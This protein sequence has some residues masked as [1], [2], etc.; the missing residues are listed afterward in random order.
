MNR[1]W[2]TGFAIVLLLAPCTLAAQTVKGMVREQSDGRPVAGAL[3]TLLGMGGAARARSLTR[4]DG[5]YALTAPTAG[6]YRLRVERIGYSAT[7]SPP[8]HLV[9]GET[10]IYDPIAAVHSV[11]LNGI[12]VHGKRRCVVR[13]AEGEAVATVWDEARKALE[14]ARRTSRRHLV[15]YD[16][17]TYRQRLDP[18]TLHILNQTSKVGRIRG[19]RPFQSLPAAQLAHQGFIAATSSGRVYY[20][21]DP[22][23]LLSDAFL[24]THCFGLARPEK[25]DTTLV[26]LHFR[27]VRHRNVADIEGTFWLNRRTDRLESLRFHYTDDLDRTVDSGD[28]GGYEAFEALP[29]GVWIIRHWWIRAPRLQFGERRWSVSG[30]YEIG[31]EVTDLLAAR[32]GRLP[33]ALPGVHGRPVIPNGVTVPGGMVMPDMQAIGRM[34]ASIGGEVRA[35]GVGLD[36]PGAV[37]TLMG[38]DG[39]VEARKRSDAHGGFVF[40]GLS[41]GTYTIRAQAPGF[42][43]AVHVHVLVQSDEAA[44]V[45]LSLDPK[46]FTLPKLRVEVRRRD[47]TFVQQQI[48]MNVHSFAPSDLVLSA[49]LKELAVG[50]LR[51]TDLLRKATVPGLVILPGPHGTEGSCFWID[52]TVDNYGQPI[53]AEVYLDD[54]RVDPD[55]FWSLDSDL[56]DLGAIVVLRPDEAGALFG[57]GAMGGVVLIYT[58]DVMGLTPR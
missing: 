1:T 49:R 25:H 18:S 6:V 8:L 48:G 40:Q 20:A 28:L 5:G 55:M 23:V 33:H 42:L 37:V 53:C 50:S 2:L 52:G 15:A 41:A 46:P 36:V 11:S 58:R 30:V 13:P 54:V 24:D 7:T 32:R 12:V 10:L 4:D 27:P 21:P 29:S 56:T 39:G 17:R 44:H 31:G 47:E 38:A 22:D 35:Q 14:I 45:T 16:L 19:A 26:G 9:A 34:H 51:F 43:R 57:T 3:V